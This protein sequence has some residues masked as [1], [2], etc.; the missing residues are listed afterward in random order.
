[1]EKS[2][3]DDGEEEGEDDNYFEGIQRAVEPAKGEGSKKNFSR[4]QKN[5]K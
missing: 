1:M 5:E 4:R 3:E 2:S